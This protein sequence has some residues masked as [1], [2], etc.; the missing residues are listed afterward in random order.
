[1]EDSNRNRRSGA[2]VSEPLGRFRGP[3]M[4]PRPERPIVTIVE[5]V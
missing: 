5:R 4:G 2:S 3:L 1:M